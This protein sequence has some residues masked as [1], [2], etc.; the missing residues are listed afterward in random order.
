MREALGSSLS[1]VGLRSAGLR[2]TPVRWQRT[3]RLRAFLIIKFRRES[4]FPTLGLGLLH[5]TTNCVKDHL[6]LP[7]VSILQLR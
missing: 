4:D 2:R 1:V 7:I 3:V 6:E 5:Q